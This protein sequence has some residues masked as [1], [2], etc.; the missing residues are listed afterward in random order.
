[1]RDMLQLYR[2]HSR[3]CPH[4]KKGRRYTKCKC[5]I[6]VDGE[7]HGKRFRRSTGVR[8][9]QRALRKIAAW[10]NPDTPVLKRVDE[11]IEAFI[12]HCGDLSPAS[13]RKYQN[14]LN[15]LGSFCEQQHVETVS[16]ITVEVMDDFRAQRAISPLTASKEVHTLRLFLVFCLRRRWL[17]HNVAKDIDPPK[18]VKPKEVIPYT[19]AEVAHIVAACAE[20]GK[21]PYERCRSRAMVLLMRYTALRISDVMTLARS[22]IREGMIH[23]HTQKTSAVVRLPIPLALQQAL[24]ELPVPKGSRTGCPYF[25]WNGHTSRRQIVTM[26]HKTLSAV[27]RKARV[28]DATSHR[29]RHTL[30]TEI[31]S[32]GGTIQDVADV[33]GISAHVADRHYAKWSQARDERIVRIMEQVHGRVYGLRPDDEEALAVQ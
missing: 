12:R 32:K 7:L 25:F 1:M 17:T 10:E 18:G 9:W 16:E 3:T 23:L 11:A 22:R 14:V 5:L 6:A 28:A 21:Q 24:D 15:Q 4:R 20:I 31:L 2:R 30:A 26:G 29:F 33:L 13:L 27:F 8:D 19:E